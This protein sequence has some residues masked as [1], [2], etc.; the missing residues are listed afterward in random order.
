MRGANSWLAIALVALIGVGGYSLFAQR[1]AT[2]KIN[3]L[4][5]EKQLLQQDSQ[6]LQKDLQTA[7]ADNDRL[8]RALGGIQATLARRPGLDK[9]ETVV[10]AFLRE[11][12]AGHF[13]QA[14]LYLEKDS[15][16]PE[17][18]LKGVKST[19]ISGSDA[20]ETGATVYTRVRTS[21]DQV[22]SWTF[23]VAQRNDINGRA[24]WVIIGLGPTLPGS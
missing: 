20:T 9:P 5:K 11:V 17:P 3:D 8:R 24:M 10:D 4:N 15:L 16:L 7:A 12:M 1:A 21:D 13:D 23:T 14:R 19:F 22:A 18:W 2:N 6:K